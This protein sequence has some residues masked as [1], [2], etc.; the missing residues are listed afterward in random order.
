MIYTTVLGQ[1]LE[2]PLTKNLE[3]LKVIKKCLLFSIFILSHNAYS[4]YYETLPK[5][6]RLVLNRYIQS[7]VTSSFNSSQAETPFFTQ[8]DV[9]IKT[10]EQIEE[11]LIQDVLSSLRP[12]NKAYDQ[13]NLGTH[14]IDASADLSVNVYGYAHGITDRVTAYVGIPIFDA[15]V[16]VKYKRTKAPTTKEVSTILQEE[17]G[18]NI[19]QGIGGIVENF[20]D[21][22][23]PTI[24]SAIVNGFNYDE[25]GSWRGQGLGDIELGVRYNF[26]KE[27]NYGLMVTGGLNLPTGYV[28]DPDIIQDIS[29]GDGQLDA[30]VEFGG[31]MNIKKDLIF[32][33]FT[34]FTYQFESDKTLRAPISENFALNDTK[35]RFTEK[36]GN[37]FLLTTQ[38]EYHPTDWLKIE[39]SLIYNYIGKADYSSNNQTANRLLA[40]NTEASSTSLRLMGQISSVNLYKQKKFLLPAHIY[41]AYENMVYGKNIPKADILEVEFRMYF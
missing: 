33:A 32:N 23:A 31:G 2:L 34:R 27:N 22:D 4:Q 25:V 11:P 17:Y 35:S 19:A 15:N 5:G 3:Y 10:L 1:Y 14:E 36:L 28:N 24:Q 13:I 21:I 37:R 6:V 39:P 41:F 8:I 16:N 38:L 12:Y 26:L 40:L 29:F 20:Y 18:D 9:D 7:N 30:F